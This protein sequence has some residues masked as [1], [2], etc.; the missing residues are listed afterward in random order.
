MATVSKHALSDKRDK[1]P[2]LGKN[3]HFIGFLANTD[4]SIL[5]MSLDHGFRIEALPQDKAMDSPFTVLLTV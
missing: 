1:K 3:V 2:T 4:A 5:Q